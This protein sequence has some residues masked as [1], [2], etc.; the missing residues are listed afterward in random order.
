MIYPEVARLIEQIDCPRITYEPEKN[1]T[2]VFLDTRFK[3]WYYHLFRIFLSSVGPEWNLTILCPS[4]HIPKYRHMLE[5]RLGCESRILELGTDI[6]T[7][8][9]YNRLLTDPNFYRQIP[10][11]TM[12]IFQ[13]DSQA[14][15][16]FDPRYLGYNY[17][18]AFW[19]KGIMGL[20]FGNG[21]T[22]LRKTRVIQRLLEQNPYRIRIN[23]DVYISK[24]IQDAGLM[25]CPLDDAK[26]FSSE[27]V[28][29]PYSIY[30]H[31]LYAYIGHHRLKEYWVRTLENWIMEQRSCGAIRKEISLFNL[32][33]QPG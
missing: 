15:R 3:D 9:A 20:W 6:T 32:A 31:K 5:T 18:G 26:K 30:G 16:P 12:L 1:K 22:S 27:Q 25:N 29:D 33:E 4:E 2:L 17:V 23:E 28:L 10:E 8:G 19:K 13:S 14:F 21:G 24:L 7:I 11:E